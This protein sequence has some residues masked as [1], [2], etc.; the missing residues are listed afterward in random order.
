MLSYIRYRA[1]KKEYESHIADL[2]TSKV[3]NEQE[4]KE[5][6]KELKKYKDLVN[7]RPF[8]LTSMEDTLTP[9]REKIEELTMLL[10]NEEEKGKYLEEK[11]ANMEAQ[12]HELKDILKVR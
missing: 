1:E 6:Q 4:I 10:Q 7:E 3:K 12:Y 11:L 8:Y 2:E 9:Y 5:L